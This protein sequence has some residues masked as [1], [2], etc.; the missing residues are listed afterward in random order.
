MKKY[1]IL[2]LL[3]LCS[4]FLF[5]CKETPED[6]KKKSVELM[7]TQTMGLAYL[8]EFKLDDAEKVNDEIHHS[9]DE[10]LATKK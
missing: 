6:A 3:V 2:L 10:K 5:S 9:I 8:E 1:N 4:S 7:T